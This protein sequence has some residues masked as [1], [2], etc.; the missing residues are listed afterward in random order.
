MLQSSIDVSVRAMEG[1]GQKYAANAAAT[2]L[3]LN[4]AFVEECQQRFGLSY[5]VSYAFN[6]AH[7]VSFAGKDV[8]EVGGS[9]PPGFV[10]DVLGAKTWTAI[11]TPDYEDEL[12][13]A[14]GLTHKGTLLHT[15]TDVIPTKGFGTPFAARYNFS[16]ANIEDLPESHREKYDLVFSIAT[17]EHVQKM[18]AALDR[19]HQALKPG[20]KLFSFFSPIWSAHDGH[21]FPE[22]ADASGRPVDRSIIPPWGHLL[23][24]P[25]EMYR[26]LCTRTDPETAG[27]MVY[28]IYHASFINRLFTED[29]IAYI[30]QTPFRVT[31]L[32]RAF[33]T[34]V[35]PNIQ[36]ALTTLYPG[37]K[38]F[39]NNGLYIILEK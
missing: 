37:R 26:F 14:G 11:E 3:F 12:A 22:I 13:E 39:D 4:P 30:A 5:H 31:N 27:T 2:N 36:S 38:H 6:C 28:Y 29:Y 9:L 33:T 10:F 19:M 25:P 8:L 20:G 35:P 24:P 21:H 1:A 18:P 7:N 23:A 16:L 34:T 15:D 32:T 17:F